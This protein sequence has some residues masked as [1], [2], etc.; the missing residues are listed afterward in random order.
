MNSENYINFLKF[1]ELYKKSSEKSYA[2][3]K[4][5]LTCENKAE[6]I[7]ALSNIFIVDDLGEN[8]QFSIDLYTDKIRIFRDKHTFF[9]DF[10]EKETR[11]DFA[12]IYSDDSFLF[13]SHLDKKTFTLDSNSQV[14]ESENRLVNNQHSGQFYEEW[15]EKLSSE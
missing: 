6:E 14:V 13:F 9:K 10:N 15:R 4:V 7:E 2:G 1:Y 3:R 12:I 5:I 11:I 8:N